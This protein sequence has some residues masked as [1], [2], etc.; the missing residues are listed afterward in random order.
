MNRN[1]I[2]V[3]GGALGVA[4]VVAL[5]VQVSLG[6]KKQ[7]VSKSQV[8]ILVAV[9][10]MAA[11]QTLKEGD[12]RWQEWP[13]SSVF[14]GTFVRDKK[15]EAGKAVSGRLARSVAKGEP[16]VKSALMG[17]SKGNFV[18]GSLEPGMR[19]VAID[20]KASAMVGGFIGPGDRVDVILTYKTTFAPDDDDPGVKNMVERTIQRMATETILQNLKV[21]AVDQM[22]KAPEDNKVKVGKTV[23]LAMTAEDSEKIALAGSMGD[24]TLALRGVGDDKLVIKDWKTASDARLVTIDDDIFTEYKKMRKGAGVRSD[25]VRIYSGTSVELVPSQ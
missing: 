11:G 2:I 19:A 16:L 8:E 12:V 10:D 4:L 25:S 3:L 21:L 20:V 13:Q 23:T 15:Q 6:G 5:L 14:A 9:K 22:A 24:L 18:A 1:V 17:E 7:T